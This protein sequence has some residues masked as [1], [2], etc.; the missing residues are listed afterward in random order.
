[1]ATQPFP[2]RLFTAVEMTS[3]L[4]DLGLSPGG[5]LVVKKRDFNLSS[6]ASGEEKHL[7][8]VVLLL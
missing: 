3:T 8:N 6:T 5:S 1:M 2:H 7:F 4:A